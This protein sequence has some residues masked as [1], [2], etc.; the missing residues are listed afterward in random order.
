M[1]KAN[2]VEF[3]YQILNLI[4]IFMNFSFMIFGSYQAYKSRKIVKSFK[5]NLNRNNHELPTTR[6]F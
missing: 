4:I 6:R 3:T 5:E 2:N 1:L